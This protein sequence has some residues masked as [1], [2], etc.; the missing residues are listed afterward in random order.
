MDYGTTHEAPPCIVVDPIALSK[1]YY[2]FGEEQPQSPTPLRLQPP[3][4][5]RAGPTDGRQSRPGNSIR[6]RG[7]PGAITPRGW[8]ATGAREPL[9]SPIGTGARKLATG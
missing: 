2:G 5:A 3:A 4:A 8:P 1:L 9:P 7:L 6:P